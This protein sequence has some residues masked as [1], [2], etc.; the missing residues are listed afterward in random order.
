M[1]QRSERVDELRR[2]EQLFQ[3]AVVFLGARLG[4]QGSAVEFEVEFAGQ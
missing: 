2:R 3:F 1:V 4:G